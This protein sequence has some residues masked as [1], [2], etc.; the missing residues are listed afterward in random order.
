MV[1]MTGKMNY[2]L[3]VIKYFTHNEWTF[4]SD[5][6]IALW[7]QLNPID[8]KEF[9]FDMASIDWPEMAKKCYLGN[10]RFLLKETEDTIPSARKR[11]HRLGLINKLFKFILINERN[12]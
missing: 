4:K 7:S 1:K 2:G 12:F 10:R 9:N 3:E 8:Q 11:M 6:L 5:N